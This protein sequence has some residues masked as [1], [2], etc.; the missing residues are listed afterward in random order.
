MFTQAR[1]IMLSYI[2]ETI[3]KGMWFLAMHHDEIN[4]YEL[5]YDIHNEEEMHEFTRINGFPVKPHIFIEGNPNVP[6]ETF[7]VADGDEIGWFDEGE[8]S[9]ELHDITLKEINN[10]LE[11]GGYCEIEV[12]EQHLDDSETQ[13]DYIQ[14]VPVLLQGKVTIKYEDELDQVVPDYDDDPTWEYED[15]DEEDDNRNDDD[16]KDDWDFH[17]H[18]NF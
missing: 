5:G 12:E 11:N 9:D 4:V 16:D 15:D 13:E 1:L 10:I 3:K 18:Y 2:P 17:S 8:H 7:T 6:D 14:I